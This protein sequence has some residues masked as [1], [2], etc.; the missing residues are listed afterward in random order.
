MSNHK[1]AGGLGFRDFRDFNLTMLGNQGWR[2]LTNP[3]SLVGHIYKA[4]YFPK[5]NFLEAILENNPS[6]IWMSIWEAKLVIVVGARWKVG[7]GDKINITGQ[8]W[9]SDEQNP[10]ISSDSRVLAQN[11][12]STLM[13]N[14][15]RVWD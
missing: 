8:P 3:R 11:T 13:C 5:T 2:L 15:E 4:R 6:F 12:V 10:F 9:L 7:R 1:S 14:N